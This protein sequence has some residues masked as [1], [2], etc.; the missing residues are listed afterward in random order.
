MLLGKDEYHPEPGNKWLDL[1]EM[2]RRAFRLRDVHPWSI[3][4][5][6]RRRRHIDPDYQWPTYQGVLG[7]HEGFVVES[8]GLRIE[9]GP[10]ALT[11]SKALDVRKQQPDQ[12][13]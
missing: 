12:D 1:L 8:D 13:F 7:S 2:A 11:V 9:G 10:E 4:C 6:G 5:Y 3:V